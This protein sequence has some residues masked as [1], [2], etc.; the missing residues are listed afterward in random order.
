MNKVLALDKVPA[1]QVDGE[2]KTTILAPK[3]LK[4]K[5]ELKIVNIGTTPSFAVAAGITALPTFHFYIG[6]NLQDK[7][8]A[9]ET[10]SYK[11]SDDDIDA[12]L[13][14]E[15]MLKNHGISVRDFFE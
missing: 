10:D 12:G 13:Q 8:L 5:G 9:K 15:Q 6:K 4:G 2:T 1:L 11:P 7:I 14:H 3:A